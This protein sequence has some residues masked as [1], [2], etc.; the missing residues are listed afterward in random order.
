MPHPYQVRLQK[1][2]PKSPRDNRDWMLS[3][4]MRHGLEIPDFRDWGFPQSSLN[5][6]DT[7]HCGGFSVADKRVSPGSLLTGIPQTDAEGHKYY[8]GICEIGG[9]PNSENGVYTRD[10]ARY[11]VQ[12]GFWPGYAFAD[13]VAIAEE[14][15][16]TQDTLLFGSVWTEGMF[17]TD[18]EG[19]VHVQLGAVAGG[20]LWEVLGRDRIR[21]LWI[22]QNSWDGWGI[23]GIGR[24]YLS[25][26][27]FQFLFQSAGE[28]IAAT[29]DGQSPIPPQPTPTCG[30]YIIPRGWLYVGGKLKEA[31]S[32]K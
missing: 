24:F 17:Q 21:K 25:D 19:F 13:S 6:G 32:R 20:H 22:G 10:A 28:I 30:E 29:E 31:L 15:L 5:Q 8:Y 4:K 27:D 26:S 9:Y 16:L 2:L 1:I 7:P 23:N 3:Q 18:A 14:F 12:E 11:G